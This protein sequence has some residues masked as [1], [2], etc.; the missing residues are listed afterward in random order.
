[1]PQTAPAVH[2]GLVSLDP[3]VWVAAILTLGILSFLYRDNPFYKFTEHLFVGISAGY[4][5][6]LYW[7]QAFIPFLWHPLWYEHNWWYFLP[8][9]LG[10]LF[11]TR[12]IPKVSFLVLLPLAFYLGAANGNAIPPTINADIIK[13]IQGTVVTHVGFDWETVNSL[14]ILIGVIGT[15]SY[16]FFSREHK[17]SLGVFARIGILFIMIG[18][19]T[20]FGFTVMARLSLLIG[21]MQFLLGEW[22]HLIR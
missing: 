21:R 15:L 3:W 2:E 6:A 22:F 11:F 12:F 10:M 16:F 13:Q 9:V 4:M 7:H 18:F 5:I 1:M 8:A 20:T 19:G 17:G 14:L